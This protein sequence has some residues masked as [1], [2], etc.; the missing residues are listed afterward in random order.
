KNNM[1]CWRRLLA[2]VRGCQASKR[3]SAQPGGARK[4]ARLG[5]AERSCTSGLYSVSGLRP[6]FS[7]SKACDAYFSIGPKNSVTNS[8]RFHLW[9][10]SVV[11]ATVR[12]SGVVVRERGVEGWEAI[13]LYSS[14][15]G[16][17]CS[18]KR[19]ARA[20]IRAWLK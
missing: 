6:M 19:G 3:I 5:Y 13:S 15:C 18:K 2:V 7:P 12:R 11:K 8:V 17:A 9:D 1:L 16:I 10:V 14:N 4:R 20:E